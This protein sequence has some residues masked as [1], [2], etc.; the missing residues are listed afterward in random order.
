MGRFRPCVTDCDLSA[1]AACYAE[2]NGRDQPEADVRH[3]ANS[4]LKQVLMLD[5]YVVADEGDVRKLGLKPRVS[6]DGPLYWFLHRYFVH[7]SLQPGDFSFLNPYE[8]T[9]IQGY[10]LHRLR[11]ELEIALVDISARNGSVPVLVGWRGESP[12][13]DSEEW[14]QVH[15]DE[16]RQTISQLMELIIEAQTEEKCLYALGD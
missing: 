3:D 8:D 13:L 9:T 6:L 2:L 1:L 12:T 10:Q 14:E 16:L 7:A 11:S 15:T 4:Y 5:F